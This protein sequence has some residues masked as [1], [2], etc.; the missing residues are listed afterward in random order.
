MKMYVRPLYCMLLFR[1]GPS[2]RREKKKS[3]LKDVSCQILSQDM[4]GND[5]CLLCPPS[6]TDMVQLSIL[7]INIK[8]AFKYFVGI[9]REDSLAS[10]IF[11]LQNLKLTK[12]VLSKRSIDL[13]FYDRCEL[14]YFLRVLLLY[15]QHIDV[16]LPGP[17]RIDALTVLEHLSDLEAGGMDVLSSQESLQACVL[18]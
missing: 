3:K 17:P 8:P 12:D 2:I 13:V 9:S 1:G 14:W 16:P 11:W 7:N 6:V 4:K 15:V 18:S 10:F 5:L